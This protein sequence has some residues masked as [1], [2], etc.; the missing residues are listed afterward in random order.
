MIK[1]SFTAYDKF[2]NHCER[3][4]WFRWIARMPE[5]PSIYLSIGNLYHAALAASLREDPVDVPALIQAAKRGP[6][7]TDVTEAELE[8]EVR[9]QL[10]RVGREV[11]PYISP[12]AVEVWS[13]SLRPEAKYCAKL[14]V[15]SSITPVANEHGEIVGTEPVKCILDWKTVFTSKKKRDQGTTDISAQLALY[16]LEAGVDRG[17]FVEIP[18]SLSM[19]IRVLGTRFDV[20]SLRRW[21]R[22]FEVQFAALNSRGAD[23]AAYKLAAPGFPLCSPRWCP[24]WRQCPGG[25]A[26][27]QG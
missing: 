22:H 21:K 20:Y 13:K 16:C 5:E 25:E 26:E 11:R 14:D 6:W 15:V 23:P 18:R 12:I 9:Q 17:V 27:A 3:Q 19:P 8:S 24:Y 1:P 7:V 10:E 4:V 2:T